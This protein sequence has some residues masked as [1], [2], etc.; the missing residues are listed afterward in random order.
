[1]INRTDEKPNTCLWLFLVLA[2]AVLGSS[3]PPSA[4]RAAVQGREQHWIGTWATA[5]QPARPANSQT[6]RNQTLRLV[7][8]TSAGGKRLRIRL[9]NIFGE[10]QLV[11]G[12][13]HIARRTTAADIDPASD[14]ILLFRG[15]SSTTIA[16]QSMVVSDPIDLEVPA[17]SDLAVSVFFPETAVATTSHSLA[18]QTNYVSAETGD[19]T[20]AVKFPASKT[21]VS[22]PFLTGVDVAASSRGT[23][24]VAFGSSTTD[25]DGSTKD[26]NR[27]W[28]DVLAERLQKSSGG[29]AELGVLNEGIIGNRLL[30][31]SP[32]QSNSPFGPLLGQA[33][34]MRF[35]RDVLA[36]AG[37]KY[38]L[39][40]LGVNDILFPAYPFT[41]ATEIV[42]PENISA[43]YRQLIARAHKNGIRVIGTTI[44]PFEGATFVGA[45]LNL[46]L[47]TPEREKARQA[48]NEW[49]RHSGKFDAV[50]DFDAVLRDPAR[51]TQL[52]PAYAADDHLHVT[53]DGNVLTVTLTGDD[54]VEYRIARVPH[55]EDSDHPPK[56]AQA[57]TCVCQLEP[58]RPLAE[59]IGWHGRRPH[60][61]RRHQFQETEC[62]DGRGV[63]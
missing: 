10:Q 4:S 26:L 61:L 27:R 50:V 25:G 60:R 16:A 7:V 22:W 54:P 51:P 15:R 49:I 2:L 33:G 28:P 31:D 48:V 30:N 63:A 19:F 42:T 56:A 44:P 41:P 14:R 40:C 12:S 34:L 57:T 1:M 46:T 23:A 36:Q 47:Y 35:E 58:N 8:H 5:A 52:L 53:D 13:A 45:G 59:A 6:F 17:L 11:I 20:A 21:L 24:I 9:S 29:T 43:G 39:I 55:P 38:V 62:P 3:N 32:K 37:V 18:L